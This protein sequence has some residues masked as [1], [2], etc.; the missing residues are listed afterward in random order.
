[1][2]FSDFPRPKIREIL[3]TRRQSCVPK[4]LTGMKRGKALSGV[5]VVVG[6]VWLRRLV[7][8]LPS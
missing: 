2:I 6:V 4:V 7:G 5:G 1:M 8:D 3:I